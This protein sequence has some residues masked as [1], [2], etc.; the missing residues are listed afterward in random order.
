MFDINFIRENRGKVEEALRNRNKKINLERLL[1]L[2]EKRRSVITEMDALRAEQNEVSK[3]SKGGVDAET[4]AKM[5]N[6]KER[7]KTLE[8][9]QGSV[10][11]EY[12]ELLS[13]IPNMP[14]AD[15]P[16]GKDE[17]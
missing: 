14:D 10:E 12:A 3:K 6:V 15:V 17:S 13:A 8:A 5:K 11:P 7:L 9:E 4:I 16:V 2:D 1:E